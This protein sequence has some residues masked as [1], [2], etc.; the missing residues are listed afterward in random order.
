MLFHE[1]HFLIRRQWPEVVGDNTFEFVTCDT[2]AVH[3]GDDH[4]AGMLGV[5]QRIAIRV[6]VEYCFQPVSG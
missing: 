1:Q 6:L 3:G 5:G 4:V 2:D